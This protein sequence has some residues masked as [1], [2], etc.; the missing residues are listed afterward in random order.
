MF[1]I[2]SEYL[3]RIASVSLFSVPWTYGLHYVIRWKWYKI[4]SFYSEFT[5]SLT[6]QSEEPHI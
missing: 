2:V 3:A 6:L 1:N 5:I 4:K